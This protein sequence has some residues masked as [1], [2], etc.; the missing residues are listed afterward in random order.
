MVHKEELDHGVL[1]MLDAVRLRVDDHPVLDGRR[2]RGLQLRNAFDL[3]KAHP[4]RADRGAELRFV[5]EERDLDVAALDGV[6]EPLVLR[7]ADLAPVDGERDPVVGHEATSTAAV[8]PETRSSACRRAAFC[9][10]S[11]NSL[12][13]CLIIEPTGIAIESPSTQRQ[14]PMMFSWTLAITSRS[15]GVAS[16]ESIRSSIFTV[17]FVPSRHGTHLPQDS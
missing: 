8:P 16:P 6:H 3:D 9:M 13:K 12:R 14:L 4:A 2:A 11:S 17:Q 1:R 15:I 10:C 7:R 5:A